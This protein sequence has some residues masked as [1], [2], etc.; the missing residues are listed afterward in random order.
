M[1]ALFLALLAPADAADRLVLK[2]SLGR[3]VIK[4]DAEKAPITVENVTRYARAGFYDGT[5]FHRV[6]AGFVIQGGGITADGVE[7]PV[8]PPIRNEASNRLSNVRGTVAMA[9]T[10]DPDSADSQFYVNLADNSRLDW[11]SD[12]PAGAGYCVFGKVIAG[13]RVVDRI[14]K[15]PTS[16]G[17]QPLTPVVIESA[18]VR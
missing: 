18:A 7:K 10:A 3:V 8:G 1:L 9:R 15:V 2:T 16:Y 14:S 12:T 5:V 13:M 6:I 17:D 11:Q 4:M